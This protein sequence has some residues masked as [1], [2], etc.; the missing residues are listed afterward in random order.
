MGNAHFLSCST[1]TWRVASGTFREARASLFHDQECKMFQNHQPFHMKCTHRDLANR[2]ASYG[3]LCW[4][5]QRLKGSWPLFSAFVTW[6]G[7]LWEDGGFNLQHKGLG[8]RRA[9][10]ERVTLH[11]ALGKPPVSLSTLASFFLHSENIPQQ[12]SLVICHPYF[13]WNHLQWK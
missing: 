12:I 5:Q 13:L 1:Q 10:S 4:T 8:A 11:L 3:S 9:N 6:W 2:N 7:E